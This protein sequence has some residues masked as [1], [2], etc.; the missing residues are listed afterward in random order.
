MSFCFAA[1]VALLGFAVNIILFRKLGQ[2]CFVLFL[3]LY[4]PVLVFYQSLLTCVLSFWLT[5]ACVVLLVFGANI[6]FS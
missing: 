6:V 5:T 2:F 3:T 4:F 1:R